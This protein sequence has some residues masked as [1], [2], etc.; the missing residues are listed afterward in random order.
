[1]VPPRRLGEGPPVR[2]FRGAMPLLRRQAPDYNHAPRW[3]ASKYA[4]APYDSAAGGP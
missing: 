3:T 4:G 2:P 1:M